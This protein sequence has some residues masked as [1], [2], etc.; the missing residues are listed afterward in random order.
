[1]TPND[2]LPIWPE[3]AQANARRSILASDL[4]IE[5]D[6]TSKGPIDVQGQIV[7]SAC[8]PEV[9][10]AAAGR[11]EGTV[12]ANNLSV[13]GLVSGSVAARL[14]QLAASAVVHA[15]ILHERI[16][17]EAGAELEGRLLRK[18]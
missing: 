15:D 13:L 1:M 6:V 10:V 3:A 2:K 12:S 16:A 14:V 8:A 11:I 9:L 18:T 5:G 4:V 7:G 17:I